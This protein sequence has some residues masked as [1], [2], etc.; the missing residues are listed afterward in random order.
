MKIHFTKSLYGI[1]SIICL[2]FNS[3]TGYS[4]WITN[5]IGNV[6]GIESYVRI[7]S[8]GGSVGAD[9]NYQGIILNQNNFDNSAAQALAFSTVPL[10]NRFKARA[11]LPFT[12]TME[13]MH[14]VTAFGPEGQTMFIEYFNAD[15]WAGPF[16]TNN[17]TIRAMLGKSG[18]PY[19]YDTDNYFDK[20]SQYVF[21]IE[22]IL[23]VSG[24]RRKTTFKKTFTFSGGRTQGWIVIGFREKNITTQLSYNNLIVLPFVVEGPYSSSI[25]SLG[26][27]TEPKVPYLVIHKPPG[28]GSF[29]QINTTSKTCR[30]FDESYSEDATNTTKASV[31]LGAKGSIGLIATIDYE[32][33][34]QFSGEVATANM[35][36]FRSSKQ[37]CVEVTNT[38][39]TSDIPATSRNGSDVFLGYG[40]D[41]AYGIGR[42]I[43]ILPNSVIKDDTSM[44]FRPIEPVRQFV[45]TKDGILADIASQ[46][47]IMNNPA[48]SN[49]ERANAQYQIDVWN[50]VIFKNDSTIAAANTPDGSPISFSAGVDGSSTSTLEYSSTSSIEVG[51]YIEGAAAIEAVVNIG[52]SG[53]SAGHEFR[54]KKSSGSAIGSGTTTTNSISYTLK[55]NDNGDIFY[56]NKYKDPIYGTPIFKT[57]TGTRSSCPF[58]GGY[59][60]DQPRIEIVGTTQNNIT[61]PNVTLGTP[62]TFQIKLCNNNTTEA[63]SYNLGFVTQSNSSDLLISAA[64]SSGSQ[65]GT[66]SVPANSCRVENY[67]VNIARRFPTSAVN[68]S[69]LELELFPACE[70]NIKS[71]IFANVS[72]AAPPPPTNVVADKTEVCT[73]TAVTL[74]ASCPVST[75]PTWYTLA[76]GG[77]PVGIGSSVTVNPPSNTTYHVGCETVNYVRDRIPTKMVLVGSPS[78]VLNLTTNF[79]TNSLQ[80]ANTTITANNK[81]ISPASVTFKAGNSLT[82]NPGFEARVGTNFMARIGGCAN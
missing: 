53:F 28:D 13:I 2:L 75:T 42:N 20:E 26:V 37:T 34:A 19:Q 27:T 33:Y 22:N 4:Q 25:D 56:V 46:Q 76:V 67:D 81:I 69:N 70:S 77:F 31:K 71:S 57:T 41:L 17:G 39:A 62:A 36:A 82:F 29:S 3:F 61:I 73:G 40:M 59:Q 11:G 23:G 14:K 35:K 79:T 1:I 49:R 47:I 65:F 48:L 18:H 12:L 52:G 6:S 9:N 44:Y 8:S 50:Q 63:R 54:T 55:D 58:E 80:I 10:A 78:T 68:F 30:N 45:L 21:W 5:T 72:F 74:S 15:N 32:I 66:F 7:T 38:W 64:G 60:R 16:D 24:A 51:H 43:S